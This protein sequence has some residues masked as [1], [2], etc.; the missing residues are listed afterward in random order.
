[1]RSPHVVTILSDHRNLTYF[2]TAQKLNRRQARW[3]LYLSEFNVK[4]IHVPGKQMIQSDA[5]SRRPDLCPDD[6]HDNEDKV[7][8]S[9][10][11]FVNTVLLSDSL[12]INA[13]DLGLKDLIISLTN[14]DNILK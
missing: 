11:M 14:D 7:L 13:I 4:L 6:D 8:L 10:S 9:E 3:S 5:L 2:R 12:F 1:M